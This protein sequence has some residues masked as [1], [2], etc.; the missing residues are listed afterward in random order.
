L[1]S[2]RTGQGPVCR[3]GRRWSRPQPGRPR[4]DPFTSVW[5]SSLVGQIRTNAPPTTRPKLED[6]PSSAD[7]TAANAKVFGQPSPRR[8]GLRVFWRRMARCSVSAAVS[9]FPDRSG[10]ERGQAVFRHGLR[11]A[12]WVR[13]HD[14][15]A[16][17]TAPFR[18]R[19]GSRGRSID[20]SCFGSLGLRDSGSGE[21]RVHGQPGPTIRTID[22]RPLASD[23][24][25]SRPY[26]PYCE[27][28]SQ[29]GAR[30]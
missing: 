9:P 19:G 7:Q 24:N 26:L 22:H 25:I 13:P 4:P 21:H 3:I 15:V 6:R 2:S 12:G 20:A 11:N 14:G 28:V 27:V 16:D 23:S 30:A 8:P 17:H 10:A 1:R 29:G 5:E 18:S